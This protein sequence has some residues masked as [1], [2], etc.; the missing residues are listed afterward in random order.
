MYNLHRVNKRNHYLSNW[1]IGCFYF[2][3]KR[4]VFG[5]VDYGW[6]RWLTG[7]GGK[8]LL[9]FFFPDTTVEHKNKLE[10]R[11]ALGS[12]LVRVFSA[13][14]KKHKPCY[15][16]DFLSLFFLKYICCWNKGGG[17]WNEEEKE[18]KNLWKGSFASVSA[19]FP[20]SAHCETLTCWITSAVSLHTCLAAFPL[21]FSTLRGSLWSCV[22]AKKKLL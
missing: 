10:T 20:H 18:K 13:K 16:R 11:R 19:H 9:I 2:E 7:R 15:L 3:R 12:T 5:G 22:V 6:Q 1:T 17:L 21:L 14:A 8:S 4:T